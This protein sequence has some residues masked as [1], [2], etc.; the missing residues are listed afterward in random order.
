MLPFLFNLS[1]TNDWLGAGA[2]K[3]KVI[4]FAGNDKSFVVLQYFDG[5]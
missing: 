4:G 2:Q 3:A 1:D 5:L